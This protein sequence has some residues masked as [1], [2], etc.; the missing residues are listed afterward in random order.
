MHPDSYIERDEFQQAWQAESVRTRVIADADLIMKEVHR[1]QRQ[2]QSMIFIRDF[3][4]VF[5]SLLMLPYWFYKGIKDSLPWT[6]WLMVPA[7]VWIIGYT[8][9]D[10]KRHPQKPS[11]PSESL[12]ASVKE[13]LKQIEHQIWLLRNVFWWYISPFAI[14]IMAFFSQVALRTSKDR[15]ELIGTMGASFVFVAGL[16]YFIYWLNQQAVRKELEPRRRRLLKLLTG[17]DDDSTEDNPR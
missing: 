7:L 6:W 13:S 3:R 14:S 17:L 5:I 8:L 9:V 4:E 2:F 1:S 10:R 12:L 15:F 16:S 11:D